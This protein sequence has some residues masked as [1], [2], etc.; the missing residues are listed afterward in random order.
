MKVTDL[1][2]QSLLAVVKPWEDDLEGDQVRL[3]FE[4]GELTVSAISDG[5]HCDA[6]IYLEA[7]NE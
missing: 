7:T 3:V 6:S 4:H 1:I 5:W 2:G